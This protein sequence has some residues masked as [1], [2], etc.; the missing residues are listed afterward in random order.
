MDDMDLHRRYLDN[1]EHQL[2]AFGAIM[3]VFLVVAVPNAKNIR[4]NLAV[5]QAAYDENTGTVSKITCVPESPA[6]FGK[7]PNKKVAEQA[8][9]DL[10][11]AT[12][13]FRTVY[14]KFKEK[15][16]KYAAEDLQRA[17]QARKHALVEAMRANPTAAMFDVALPEERSAIAEVGRG[18]VEQKVAK[19]GRLEV[20]HADFLQEKTTVEQYTLIT[21][22]NERI[23]LHPIRPFKQDLIS[24][25]EVKVAGLQLDSDLLLDGGATLGAESGELGGLTVSQTTTSASP[26]YGD[27][28]T[29][30]LLVNFQNTPPSGLPS[31]DVAGAMQQVE[32]YYADSSYGQVS[33]S[34]VVDPSAATD[35]F[36]WYQMPINQT[37][38]VNT[39]RNAAINAAKAAN[40]SLN[41]T[42]YD[43]L[44]VV[45][46]F[47]PCG[48]AGSASL[49]KSL[50]Q[51]PDGQ[52]LLSTSLIHINYATFMR[53]PGHELGHN[54]GSFHANYLYTNNYLPCIPGGSNACTNQEYGDYYSIMGTATNAS[55]NALHRE[56][57]GWLASGGGHNIQTVT[58]NGRYAIEPI[59]LFSLGTQALKIPRNN[60]EYFWIEYRQPIGS[61]DDEI[62][63]ETDDPYI[64]TGAFYHTTVN[65]VAGQSGLIKQAI[66]G[67]FT[68]PNPDP[69]EGEDEP[70][71]TLYE[72]STFIP[73]DTFVDPANGTRI[74]TISATPTVLEVDVTIGKTDFISPTVS[75]IAP[76]Y[77]TIVGFTPTLLSADA[78]DASGIEKVE[79]YSYLNGTTYLIGTDAT[80][81]YEVA[82]NALPPYQEGFFYYF[83]RAYDLS[84]AHVGFPG[85]TTDSPLGRIIL[86]RTPP[87]VSPSLSPSA[88]SILPRTAYAGTILV[89]GYATDQNGVE[90]I[91]FYKDGE[92]TPFDVLDVVGGEGDRISL[93]TA[94]ISDGSHTL[95]VKAY[96]IVQNV[97]Q[98][99]L[100]ILVDN[101]PPTTVTVGLPAGP[102]VKGTILITASAIDPIGIWKVQFEK[103]GPL[104]G[105]DT[106]PPFEATLDTTTLSDGVHWIRALA[107]NLSGLF[108][109]SDYVNITTDNTAPSTS[110]TAPITGT[111]VSKH[112]TITASATDNISGV[113]QVEFYRDANILLGNGQRA[114]PSSSLY[115]YSWDSF[116]VPNGAHTLYAKATDAL[117][118][119]ALSPTISVQTFNTSGG[120]PSGGGKKQLP[121]KPTQ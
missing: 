72:R 70:F 79:F 34:G 14:G 75:L 4:D 86:D 6:Q 112:V 47:T 55:H 96:D 3:L 30:V 25:T 85:N 119:I 82:V 63:I 21:K 62:V 116:S 20:L 65:G 57:F 11:N 38:G 10:E 45:S 93:D 22:Q 56:H 28:K 81:P 36:G 113:A 12:K 88:T 121:V 100:S 107:H 115:M 2:I 84:G 39:V 94:T 51:T 77:D 120:A 23:T 80:A 33:L 109:Y 99:T 64:T 7:K 104:I 42:T 13:E 66:P 89:T 98:A 83:A 46:D 43:R 15:K 76:P 9:F 97:G 111:E 37:C 105:I 44:M 31:A 69:E 114:A 67:G 92:A 5:I 40:P 71:F 1:K 117:G 118:N 91:E 50:V 78:Q 27:Q 58:T 32:D 16:N 60:G 41:F 68:V 101:T 24:G 103:R 87:S 54:L 53:I 35:V 61:V 110:L 106:M 90:K 102:A 49:G 17:A 29:V 48:W 8:A 19:E 95:L 73:G 18:C 108:T 52:A 26:T 74:T 59:E